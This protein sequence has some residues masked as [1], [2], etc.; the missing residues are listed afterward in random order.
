[1]SFRMTERGFATA[2]VVRTVAEAI[3]RTPSQVAL[4]WVLTRDG[5]TS[6][7]LGVRT[8]EQLDDNLG[9]LGWRLD[10]E[11]EALLDET[12]NITLGYPHNFHSWM[13]ELGM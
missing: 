2:H 8:T 3:G 11:H 5:I 10:P 13:A 7:I 6:P 4:N 12:S 9:A 1:M